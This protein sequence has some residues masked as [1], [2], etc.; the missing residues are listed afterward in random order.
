MATIYQTYADNILTGGTVS[1]ATPATGYAASTLLT[2][3]PAKRILYSSGTVTV[4]VTALAS[5]RGDIFCLPMHNLSGAVLTL[6]NGAGLSQA[7]TIPTARANGFPETLVADLSVLVP[8]ATTRT[9][10][11]WNLVISGNASNVILGGAIGI[12]TSRRETT[13]LQTGI[14]ETEAHQ[15]IEHTNVYGVPMRYDLHA[16]V[17]S[18]SGTFIA[19]NTE[20]ETIRGWFRAGH[21]VARPSLLWLDTDDT[22]T[23]L[24]G[25]WDGGLAVTREFRNQ[26]TMPFRFDEVSKGVALV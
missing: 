22:T 3:R 5:A 15:V 1:G 12:Y 6:T 7:I 24:Y 18:V 25:V 13:A 10:A 11:T 14:T 8:N 23:A 4:T 17:K 16:A 20:R 9:S 2:N 26:N 21:G 19:S